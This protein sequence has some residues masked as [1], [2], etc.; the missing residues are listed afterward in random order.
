MA[1][2]TL[3]TEILSKYARILKNFDNYTI[4]AYG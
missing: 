4:D 2:E 3:S 1:C